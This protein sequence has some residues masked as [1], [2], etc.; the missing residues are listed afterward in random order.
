MNYGVFLNDLA[1]LVRIALRMVFYVSGVFY[2]IKV[3]LSGS[4]GYFLLR[5]NPIALIMY[6]ARK[7]TIYGKYLDLYILGLWF[8]VGIILCFSVVAKMKM[9]C[10]GGSSNVFKKELKAC[11]DSMCTSSMIYTLYLPI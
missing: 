9:A 4:L 3:R 11:V 6:E 8:I 10:F 5:L 2:D 7:V 1:N